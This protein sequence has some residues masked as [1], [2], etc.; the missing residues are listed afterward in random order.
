MVMEGKRRLANV[1]LQASTQC[2]N[3]K[4]FILKHLDWGIEN[5][6]ETLQEMANSGVISLLI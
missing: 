1:F 2:W 6:C 4:E 5:S 3:V